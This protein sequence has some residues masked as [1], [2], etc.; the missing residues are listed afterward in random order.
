MP[1]S[2]PVEKPTTSPH[3]ITICGDAGTGK[4]TLAA[5]FPKPVFIR[6]ED[7]TKSLLGKDIDLLP[8]VKSEEELN[9][10]L[11]A[12]I[13]EEHDY[14]TLV[15]DSVSALERLFVQ[16]VLESDPQAKSINQAMGGYGAGW[17]AVTAKHM[18]VRKAAGI[19]NSKRGMNVVFIAH[20]D[21][22]NV[23]DPSG[24]DYQRWSLQLNRKS[25]PPYV[26][27]VDIVG[28][29]RFKSFVKTDDKGKKKVIG[30]GDR[31]ILC[32][33]EPSTVCKNRF[34]IEKPIPV[35]MGE[36]PFSAIFEG[37]K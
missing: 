9:A 4:T 36:N 28:F 21:I 20:A 27:D 18:R 6:A 23:P 33:P 31:E 12:L 14:Q 24:E 2:I 30:T 13:N 8:I 7:G 11:K 35:K 5:T 10:Q 16:T 15:I 29:L 34:G 3:I 19:L 22:E 25:Q 17:N 37:V 1:L 26:G 32:N